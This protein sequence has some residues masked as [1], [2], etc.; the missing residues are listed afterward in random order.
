MVLLCLDLHAAIT[1]WDR[2]EVVDI[3]A[4]KV[5]NKLFQY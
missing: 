5:P 3:G 4:L 1:Y 2:A